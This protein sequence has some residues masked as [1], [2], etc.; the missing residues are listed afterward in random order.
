[1]ARGKT[2][3]KNDK[4]TRRPT[5]LGHIFASSHAGCEKGGRWATFASGEKKRN[6]SQGEIWET[7]LVNTREKIQ[8]TTDLW[9][10]GIGRKHN[11]NRVN[12]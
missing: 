8:T 5:K 11:K 9:R 12:P 3:E 10:G 6:Q 4:K 2:E 1:V 7:P